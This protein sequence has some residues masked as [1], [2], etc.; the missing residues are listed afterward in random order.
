MFANKLFIFTI[1]VSGLA[2]LTSTSALTTP[3]KCGKNEFFACGSACDT[4]CAT[5]GEIC[6]I[7][8]IRCN[9]MCYC[10]DGYARNS[11][12]VCIPISKCPP[13]KKGYVRLA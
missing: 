5:L 8:N 2:F 4:T 7:V 11:A 13:K 3:L 10:N 1:L 9:D 6:P 12:N